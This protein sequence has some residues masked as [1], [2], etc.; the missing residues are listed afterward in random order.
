MGINSLIVD[1]DPLF[2]GGFALPAELLA[3]RLAK[4]GISDT[5]PYMYVRRFY[6]HSFAQALAER[7][8]DSIDLAHVE[9]RLATT[10]GALLQQ[11]AQE[12]YAE[13]RRIFGS[14]ANLGI[15]FCLVT[16]L[17]QAT[18]DELFEGLGTQVFS[19]PDP[20]PLAC[21]LSKE[22]L[23][24]ALVT[25]GSPVRNTLCLGSGGITVAASVRV[26]LSVIAIPDPMV[27]FENCTG[28]DIVV[29][30][31]GEDALNRITA[32]LRA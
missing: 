20:T 7:L 31:L 27:V 13:I 21:G 28:A 25:S 23:Q 29:D 15:S 4:Y 1:F 9:R 32:R 18:V 24:I 2:L 30:D 11:Q 5:D 26:G 16:R 6:G 22:T 14:W 8:P 10:Y 17:R 3:D 12:H 19:V